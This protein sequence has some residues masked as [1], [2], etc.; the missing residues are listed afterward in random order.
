MEEFGQHE[1]DLSDKFFV[2]S[3]KEK[4]AFYQNVHSGD[5]DRQKKFLTDATNIQ[6]LWTMPGRR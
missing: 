2:P 1:N 3:D 5:H 6:G 4:Q